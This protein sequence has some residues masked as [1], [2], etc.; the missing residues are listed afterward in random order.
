[1]DVNKGSRGGVA[2]A[3]DVEASH[4]VMRWCTSLTQS[5]TLM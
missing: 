5:N 1:M 2:P 3:G 4:R